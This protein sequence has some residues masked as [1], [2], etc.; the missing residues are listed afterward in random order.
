MT[1]NFKLAPGP[2]KDGPMVYF[3]PLD[4]ET[5]L[6]CQIPRELSR[7]VIYPALG[8]E[9]QI[10]C[11]FSGERLEIERLTIE[12][13]SSY[14]ASRDLTQLALPQVMNKVVSTVVPEARAI[15]KQIKSTLLDKPDG[16]AFLAQLYWFE[17]VGW[18]SPR[19]SIM[20]YMGWS[21][22]NANFHIKR[23]N[24]LFPLPGARALVGVSKQRSND[25][26]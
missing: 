19:V 12:S 18:G 26:G 14:L 7:L 22:A 17:F 8:L 10:D 1:N 13:N 23:I 25:I 3:G 2:R 20:S 24:K 11:T 9:V 5:G 15:E 16:P 6:R 21:R 4:P